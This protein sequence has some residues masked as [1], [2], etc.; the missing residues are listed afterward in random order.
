VAEKSELEYVKIR[1]DLPDAGDGVGGEGL[2][3]VKVGEDL[4]EVHNSPWHT[5]EINYM[6]VVRAVAPDEDTKPVFVEV[7]HRRGHRSIHVVFLN[8]S[9][10]ARDEVLGR[11]KEMGATYEGMH[12]S[13]FAIDLEPGVDFDAVADYLNDCGERGLIESRFAPQPQSMGSADLV[14]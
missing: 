9:E 7:V 6:D 12:N 8:D 14:N 3:A 11:I 2:W 4:Y 5:L 1:V 10:D 13:L